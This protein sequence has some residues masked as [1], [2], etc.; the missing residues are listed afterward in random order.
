MVLFLGHDAVVTGRD[1]VGIF[2]LD[3]TTVQKS[4]RD[5]LKRAETEGEVKNVNSLLE[6]P[7]TMILCEKKGKRELYISASAAATLSKRL[8]E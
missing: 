7:K 4:T 2:D 3:I 5:F 1:I 8:Q 6:I